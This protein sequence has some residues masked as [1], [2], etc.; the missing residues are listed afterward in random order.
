MKI[1]KIKSKSQYE[2]YTHAAMNLVAIDP[3]PES[4]EGLQLQL[5]TDYIDEYEKCRFTFDDKTD[6]IK[7]SNAWAEE[8]WDESNLPESEQS[9]PETISLA[10][11]AGS[12][13]YTEGWC[14]AMRLLKYV[15]D[16]ARESEQIDLGAGLVIEGRHYRWSTFEDWKKEN[17]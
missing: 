15:W 16:L 6:I 2:Q 10:K 8:V 7:K 11:A 1:S 14:A 13:G 3:E 5:L 9:L 4:I 12:M 17:E